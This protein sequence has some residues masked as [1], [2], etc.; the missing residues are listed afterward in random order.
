MNEILRLLEIA[1]SDYKQRNFEKAELLIGNI[2]K[3]FEA[4]IEQ[5]SKSELIMNEVASMLEYELNDG[6]ESRRIF[7]ERKLLEHC[8]KK[9]R[10][11]L[12]EP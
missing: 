4:F 6:Y 2:C 3:K 7:V 5:K 9:L 8:I 12:E 11:P 1:K 10:K